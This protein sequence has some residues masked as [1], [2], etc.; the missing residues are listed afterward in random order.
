[1]RIFEVRDI[2][3]VGAVRREITQMADRAGFNEADQGRVALVVTELATNL[4]K[5][6]GGGA[7]LAAENM[8]ADALCID[9]ASLDTG[10]GIDSLARSLADGFSTAGSQGTGMGAI[11]R[12]STL[13]DIYSRPGGGTVVFA[14]LGQGRPPFMQSSVSPALYHRSA[15]APFVPLWGAVAVPY[16]GETFCGD[17]WHVR[18]RADGLIC[19]VADG[20]GHG[21]LAAEASHK[22]IALFDQ[23]YERAPGDILQIL[24][25]GLHQTRGAAVAVV[26]IDRKAELVRVASVGNISGVIF[27]GNGTQRLMSHNG[28]VG[29]TVRKIQEVGYSM[30]SPLTLILSSDGITTSWSMERYP[31]LLERHPFTIACVLYRDHQRRTDD[32]TVLVA[33]S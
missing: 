31:G 7:M 29:H 4:V 33:K 10:P 8:V 28:T 22:A 9:C 18:E 1:M 27:G 21:A 30:A 19:L 24:H 20:L 16:P 5:H 13:L 15:S 14:R 11:L 23:S 25:A 6:A 26:L 17:G 2:S 32:A 3:Q 12:Q